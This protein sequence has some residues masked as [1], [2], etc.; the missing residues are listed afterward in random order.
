MRRR[1]LFALLL[2]TAFAVVAPGPALAACH[3]FTI[4]VS[5]STVAEGGSVTVTVTR[6]AALADSSVKVSSVNGSAAAGQDFPAVDR[7]VSMTGS[8][9]S[10]T[11]AVTTINDTASESTEMFS[12]HLSNGGGCAVNPNFSYGSDAAVQIQDNDAAPVTQPAPATVAPTA[13]PTTRA[14][15]TTVTTTTTTTTVVDETTT[16][17]DTTTT[18]DDLAL[19]SDSDDGGGGGGTVLL[20][21]LAIAL[22][23]GVGYV[24]YTLYRRRLA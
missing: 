9:T 24:G 14:T 17:G 12:L 23:G 10:Q 18:T 5:P 8:A 13:A 7:T 11:F 1:L 22:I 6:D 21:L 16:T 3:A 4:S 2:V 19:A 15:T 20:A